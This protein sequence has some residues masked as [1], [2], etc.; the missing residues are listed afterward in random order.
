VRSTDR[1]STS[2]TVVKRGWS[3]TIT[4]QFGAKDTS[5]SVKA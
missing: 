3:F 1:R 5:Q 4:Q 2:S